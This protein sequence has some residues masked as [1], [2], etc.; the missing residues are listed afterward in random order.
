MELPEPE[1]LTAIVSRYARLLVEIQSELGPRRLVLP[2]AQCFPDVFTMDAD[3]ATTLVRRMALHAGLGDVP[4]EARVVDENG[5]EAESH[6]CSSGCQVPT[7]ADGAVP[8]LVDDGDGWT[9][10][11]PSY[12]LS[13]PVVLTTTI[14]RA[15]AHVFLVET[16]PAGASVE[17][18]A[19]LTADYAAVALG[20]GPLLLEGAYI[21]SKGCGGPRVARVTNAG[22]GELAVLTALEVCMRGHSPRAVTKELGVTQAAAFKEAL[23]WAQS[24]EGLVKR[25]ANDPARVAAGDYS[26]KSAAPW[27][28]R[29]FKKKDASDEFVPAP[30]PT[31]APAAARSRVP[32][33][34]DDELRSLVEES[35]AMTSSRAEAE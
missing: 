7:E 20:F 21:Y 27:L 9:L 19:D 33:P 8:R 12:E 28:V 31:R 22:L 17:A 13:H 34:H 2:N 30:A 18:P 32:N 24:N 1:A 6:G 29:L 15:M 23:E 16:L 5:A 35:L 26:L 3:G 4:I 14:A 11:V 25:L 10:N